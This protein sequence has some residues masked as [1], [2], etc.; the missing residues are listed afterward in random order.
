MNKEFHELVLGDVIWATESDIGKHI[1]IICGSV[2]GE[3]G[4]RIKI[5][6]CKSWHF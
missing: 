5:N 6:C 4:K 3:Q 1:C 2:I